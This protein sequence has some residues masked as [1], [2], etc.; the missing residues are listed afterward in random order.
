M[1][2]EPAERIVQ[3]GEFESTDPAFAGEM[4]MTWTF[5]PSATGTTIAITATNV[6][7]GVSQADHDAGLR[8]S[9]QNLARYLA[10]H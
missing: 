10:S 3:S 5:A 1:S 6:P 2:L 7:P 8:E 9:L 4:L